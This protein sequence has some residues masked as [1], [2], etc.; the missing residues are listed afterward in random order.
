MPGSND[1]LTGVG[2]ARLGLICLRTSESRHFKN[3]KTRFKN[4]LDLSSSD[5]LLN[6][7]AHTK[8]FKDLI[9]FD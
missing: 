5:E 9:G 3:R 4:I 6:Y 2:F 7:V 1:S 8:I